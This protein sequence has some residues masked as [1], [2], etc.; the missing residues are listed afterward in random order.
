MCDLDGV[1]P[2]ADFKA[3]FGDLA[4]PLPDG[5]VVGS[6]G[7]DWPEVLKAL[8]QRGWS[9]KGNQDGAPI[10]PGD[11]RDPDRSG[12]SFAVRPTLVVQVNFF[13]DDEV[14]FDIDLREVEDQVALDAVYE[15][16]AVLGKS[17]QRPVTIS[18][19]G[20]FDDVVVRYEPGTD[21]F[22]LG[23]AATH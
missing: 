9:A 5:Q 6:N 14:V 13:L 4:A 17:L 1:I 16:V 11:L 18:H 12:A 23:P 15:L 19:E 2:L 20:S 21:Q 8:E 7:S 3:A 10:E 22:T